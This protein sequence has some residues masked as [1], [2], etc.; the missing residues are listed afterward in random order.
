M[1]KQ[2]FTSTLQTILK[3]TAED[4]PRD[5]DLFPH[6]HQRVVNPFYKSK[7]IRLQ[8][9]P[10]HIIGVLLVAAI[11]VSGFAYAVPTLFQWLGDQSLQTIT[12]DHATTI[13]RQIVV[14]GITLHL[15]Q[16]YAD[17]ARTT[18]TFHVSDVSSSLLPTPDPPVLTDAYNQQ[19]RQ[20]VGQEVHD[21]ALIEF[22]PLSQDRLNSSQTLLFTVSHMVIHNAKGDPI[23]SVDGVWQISFQLKPLAGNSIVFHNTPLAHNGLALQLLEL[24]IAPSGTRLFLQ[25]SGLAPN[26]SLSTLSQFTTQIEISGTSPDHTGV[27]LSGGSDGALLQLHLS[28]G[29]VLVPAF[30]KPWDASTTRIIEPPPSDQA[31]GPSGKAELEVVFYSA[32]ST[33][34]G[35]ARLMID[36]L[37][38]AD[39]RDPTSVRTIS[40]PWIFPIALSSTSAS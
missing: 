34:Q 15:D 18:V 32:L 39:Y 25:V 26:T 16:A 10:Q 5:I 2:D 31:V 33:N 4:V 28:N 12:L 36:Q 8:R 21:Q 20:V 14:K 29:Q 38:I 19:Y 1:S 6:L 23:S 40:G 22:E 7:S 17:A 24:N 13:N 27:H 35:T 30:V 9:K 3:R 37:H 11:L